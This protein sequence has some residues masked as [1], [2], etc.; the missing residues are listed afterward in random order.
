LLPYK[1]CQTRV[2]A[3]GRRTSPPERS[4]QV[5]TPD[6]AILA[7]AGLWQLEPA[8]DWS[9]QA[10]RIYDIVLSGLQQST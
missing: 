2:S 7:L 10:Q 6:D 5:S 1:R 8:S 4:A 3:G 9:A